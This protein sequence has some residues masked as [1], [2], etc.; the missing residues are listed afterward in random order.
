MW[1][2]HTAQ[3][4]GR[5]V[6]FLPA[7]RLLTDHPCNL[8]KTKHQWTTKKEGEKKSGK[9]F[10]I[11][12]CYVKVFRLVMENTRSALRLNGQDY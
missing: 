2:G 11:P 5:K 12:I 6:V 9:T 3:P 8:L 10:R 1:N 4:A 7:E